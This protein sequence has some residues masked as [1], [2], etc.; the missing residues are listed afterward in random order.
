MVQVKA[1]PNN[2]DAEIAI[3]GGCLLF[4][5]V[6]RVSGIIGPQDFYSD[7]HKFIFEAMQGLE[8]GV[9]KEFF[10]KIIGGRVAA[11]QV[12]GGECVFK[13]FIQHLGQ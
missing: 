2:I 3:L 7:R 12:P 1:L 9:F 4:P 8:R 6:R 11:K 13:I 10:V 5:N